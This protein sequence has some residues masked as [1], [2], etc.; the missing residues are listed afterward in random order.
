MDND[1]LLSQDRL[2]LHCLH[3]VITHLLA[4]CFPQSNAFG[5]KVQV[6]SQLEGLSY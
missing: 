3:A 2:E 5:A 1:L 4:S 6:F